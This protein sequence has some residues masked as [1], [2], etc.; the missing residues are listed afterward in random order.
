MKACTRGHQYDKSKRRCPECKRISSN[1][2][3]AANQDKVAD[4]NKKHRDANTLKIKARS[5][6]QNARKLD[7][8][9]T[10]TEDQLLE[11]FLRQAGSTTLAQIC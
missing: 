1:E 3:Y 10:I 4:I 2:Y 7:A 6:N 11:M 9:G 8:E 5:A